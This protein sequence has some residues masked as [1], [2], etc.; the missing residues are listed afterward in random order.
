[1][2]KL[3]EALANIV[4]PDKMA[5]IEPFYFNLHCML[6]YTPPHFSGGVLCF[7]VGRPSVCP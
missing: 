1:M 2:G 3:R 6:F 7:Q 4:D 5:C